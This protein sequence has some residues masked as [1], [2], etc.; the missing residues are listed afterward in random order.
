M[1]N[2]LAPKIEV[3]PHQQKNGKYFGG[4]SISPELALDLLF[5]ES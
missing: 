3:I 1:E 4:L 2:L 5:H